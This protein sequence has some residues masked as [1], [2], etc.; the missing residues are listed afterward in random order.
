[1]AEPGPPIERLVRTVQESAKYR[2]VCPDLIR[3]LGEREL[4]KRRSLKEAVKETKNTLHQVAGAYLERTPRYDRWITD[5]RQAPDGAARKEVGRAILAEH[6]STC[7]RLPYLEAFYQTA[8]AEIGPVR[9]VLDIA[10][11]LNPLTV[12]WMPAAPAGAIR[13][14]AHDIYADMMTFLNNFFGVLEIEGEAHMTDVAVAAP[15]DEADIALI[16]KFL[17][18]LE[19]TERGTAQRWLRSLRTRYLLVSFPTRSL[20]GHGRGRTEHYEGWFR[21]LLQAETWTAQRYQF[22]NELCFLIERDATQL[23]EKI[24]PSPHDES[25]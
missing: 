17:P 19:Q 9:S 20:G 23:I 12:S 15:Q 18:V 11:G 6:A 3:R 24:D 10:C 8:L 5:L 7:E 21:E 13:Y 16:L 1:M 2:H 14:Y 4:S 22:P 25:I